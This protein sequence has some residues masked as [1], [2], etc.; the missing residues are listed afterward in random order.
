MTRR[1]TIVERDPWQALKK[2]VLMLTQHSA[3]ASNRQPL[4][5]ALMP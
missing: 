4:R 5:L 1:M 3:R 2:I